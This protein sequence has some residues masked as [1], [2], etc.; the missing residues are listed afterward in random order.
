MSIYGNSQE[1]RHFQE[2]LYIHLEEHDLFICDHCGNEFE[3]YNDKEDKTRAIISDG[4]TIDVC[5]DGCFDE[6]TEENET[7]LT[8]QQL[9]LYS[10]MR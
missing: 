10:K 4:E 6:V 9:I 8:P 7:F 2:K 5:K 1:D 3:G